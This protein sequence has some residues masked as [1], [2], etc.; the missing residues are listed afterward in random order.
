MFLSS[1]PQNAFVAALFVFIYIILGLISL[2][3]LKAHHQHCPLHFCR[4][5]RPLS[6][7]FSYILDC[8]WSEVEWQDSHWQQHI[9]WLFP[10]SSHFKI[11]YVQYKIFYIFVGLTYGVLLCFFCPCLIC[12]YILYFLTFIDGSELRGRYRVLLEHVYDQDVIEIQEVINMEV[13][14]KDNE[15]RN[16][17]YFPMMM[18]RLFLID[19]CEYDPNEHYIFACHPHSFLPICSGFNL[20]MK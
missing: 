18:A 1:L 3:L 4:F 19:T 12:P 20:C 11:D 8:L 16:Q 5:L 14:E 13:V 7:L 17:L 9:V 10:S 15:N 2:Y 6:A